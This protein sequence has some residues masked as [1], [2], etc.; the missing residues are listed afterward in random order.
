MAKRFERL[1]QLPPNLYVERAPVILAAGVLSKDNETGNIIAQLKFQSVSEKRIK[2]VKVSIVAYDV[3]NAEVQGVTDYQ[4]L[5]LNIDNGD[6]FGSNKAIVMPVA[7][8][9]AFAVGSILVV[10]KDGSMWESTGEF[11]VLPAKKSLTFALSGLEMEQQYRLATNDSAAYIPIE[12]QDL[13][14]CSCGTWNKEIICT[15]CRIYKSKVFSALDSD[16]LEEQMSIRLAKEQE[17]R[18]AEA[19][20]QAQL[21]AEAEARRNKIKKR[22]TIFAIIALAVV[23][24][25]VGGIMVYKKVTELTIEEMLALYTKDDVVAL[26]GKPD[27]DANVVQYDVSFMGETYSLMLTYN[28]GKLNH[29]SMSY[30]YPGIDK[31]DSIFDIPDY[32]ITTKDRDA[33]HNVR[34]ELIKTFEEKFGEPQIID[35]EK[36]IT[37]YT[38]VVND[39][40]IEVWDYRGNRDL[41]L[42]QAISVRVNCDHQSFCKHVN[43]ETENINATCTTDGYYKAICTSCGYI[44]ETINKAFGHN[45]TQEIIKEPSCDEEGIVAEICT[46]CDIVVEEKVSA[47]GHHYED[48]IVVA[49]T[50]TTNGIKIGICTECG[51]EAEQ[52]EIGALGHSM[53]GASKTCS[54]CGYTDGIK[55]SSS[56]L[57]GTWEG[58]Y[59][60][61]L[62]SILTLSGNTFTWTEYYSEELIAG[63]DDNPFYF[64]I[65]GTFLIVDENCMEFYYENEIKCYYNG[66]TVDFTEPGAGVY[67]EISERESSKFRMGNVY[68]YRQ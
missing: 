24:L 54:R 17:Q 60:G 32:Y 40:M 43:A 5:E 39:R 58:Y 7:V 11:A 6:E 52:T 2:A 55:L 14:Q 50:C 1:F 56:Y 22:L 12:Y 34:E 44:T 4:Y 15:Q 10:F 48:K 42:V 66:L 49:A 68:Y 21:Q 59:N 65:T 31:L 57:Q 61:S 38:W 20:L 3:S 35:L 46:A 36:N 27:E 25:L 26:I 53:S 63:F 33:A 45:Y 29:W 41:S 51:C 23:I 13:W 9:R 47:L 62:N 67:R 64:Y 18:E 37:S 8:T 28:G 16:V 19:A 30:S